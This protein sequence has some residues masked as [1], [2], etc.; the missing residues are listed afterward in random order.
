MRKQGID[1]ISVLILRCFLY[2]ISNG[3][4]KNKD[5]TLEIILTCK[6]STGVVNSL[7]AFPFLTVNFVLR[8]FRLVDQPLISWILTADL[9]AEKTLISRLL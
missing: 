3:L 4:K 8:V 9:G 5:T 2:C 1:D 6:K 7:D